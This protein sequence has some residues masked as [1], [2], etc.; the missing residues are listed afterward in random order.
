LARSIAESYQRGEL[1]P[2]LPGHPADPASRRRAVER[3]V[4]PLAAEVAD[5]LERQNARLAPSAR[6]DAHLAALREGAAAV[7][8]GQQVGLFLGPLF[9]IYKAAAAI[10]DAR[11]LAEETG[12]PVVPVFWLQTEDHDLPEISCVRLP[13]ASG[14]EVR[15]ELPA[16]AAERISVAHRALPDAIGPCL[17]R[18]EATIGDLPEGPA[19]LARLRRH[20]RPGA[21][22]AEAFAGVLAELFDELVIVDPRDPALAAAA[23]P[24]HR[25]AIEGAEVIAN[26]LLDRCRA[27]EAAGFAPAVHVRPGAPL[28]FFHPRGAEGPRHRLEPTSGG[29]AEVGGGGVHRREAL[30]AALERD[31][32]CCSTSALLRPIVQDTLLPTA[33]Y[34]GGPGEIAYFAQLAPLYRVFDL[35]MPMVVPRA[36][37]C[38]VEGRTRRLLDRYG[39]APAEAAA[40]EEALLARCGAGDDLPTPE[41]VE[42]SLLAS[43]TAELGRLEAAV[44]P[45]SLDR[46]FGRTRRSVE[47]AVGRLVGRYA[48][49]RLQRDERIVADVRKLLRLLF[50]GGAPQERVHGLAWY[51]ARYGERAFLDAVLA[52]ARP[53]DGSLQELRP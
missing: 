1:G 25:R 43:F 24:V 50:P 2:F 10:R 14:Y 46:A 6:R 13:D 5:A 52:A 45:G 18:L 33:A 38:V 12:V 36:R 19:H 9:T 21:R 47:R 23:A 49:A 40:G 29:F 11:A 22:W 27:L 32:R 7:V 31:P 44:G 53:F 41:E 4:R 35:P 34:V 26:T 39:L 28:S 48:R 16:S 20:Y 3:A 17:D 8:T 15:L 42:R 37:F 30:L 51:A